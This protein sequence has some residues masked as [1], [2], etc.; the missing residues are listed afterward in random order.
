MSKNLHLEHIEDLMLMFGT[1]GIKESFDYIDDLVRTFSANP[2]GNRNI[3]HKMGRCSCY[4]LWSRP[5]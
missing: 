1:D 2:S 3:S 5:I 4:F